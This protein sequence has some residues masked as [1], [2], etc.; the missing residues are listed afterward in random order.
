MSRRFSLIDLIETYRTNRTRATPHDINVR[1][2]VFIQ[3]S[4]R[5]REVSI[6][7]EALINLGKRRDGRY[8][9]DALH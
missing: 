7:R 3:K 5:P 4:F 1:A 6:I 2:S 8:R 9:V